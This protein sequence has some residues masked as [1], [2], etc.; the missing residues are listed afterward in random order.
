MI[1]K[2]VG[3]HSQWVDII[4]SRPTPYYQVGANT[5]TVRYNQTDRNVEIWD[6]DTWR[7]ISGS[8]TVGLNDRADEVLLW[9]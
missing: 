4:D 8:V 5:G 6:G 7:Q 1:V 9:A 2:N 3:S